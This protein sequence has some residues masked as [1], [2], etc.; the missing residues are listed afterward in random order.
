MTHTPRPPDDAPAPSSHRDH[1]RIIEGADS[2][3]VDLRDPLATLP[4]DLQTIV[5]HGE[6]LLCEEF[7]GIFGPETVHRFL[8]ESLLAFP[9]ARSSPSC[10]SSWSG[11][12]ASDCAPSPASKA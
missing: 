10:R 7:A 8:G 6:R 2:P 4:I 1:P 3:A 11:S 9:N 12:H 5:R